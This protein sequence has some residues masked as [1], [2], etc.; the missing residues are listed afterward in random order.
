[1]SKLAVILPYNEKHIK[2]FT[3]HFSSVVE[4]KVP[5]K[6]AIRAAMITASDYVSCVLVKRDECLAEFEAQDKRR[7]SNTMDLLNFD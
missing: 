5:R 3:E 7:R 4:Q 2:D 1:M 6:K